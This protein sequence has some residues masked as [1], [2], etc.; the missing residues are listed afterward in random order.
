MKRLFRHGTLLLL[1][2]LYLGHGMNACYYATLLPETGQEREEEGRAYRELSGL[3][4]ETV[5]GVEGSAAFHAE[6]LFR[7]PARDFLPLLE[8]EHGRAFAPR[9]RHARR[10]C[11]RAFA[12]RQETGYYVFSLREIIV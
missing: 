12:L 1:T 11:L 6:P 3:S 2:L 5:L 10:A 7:Y 4:G 8:Q 9:Y